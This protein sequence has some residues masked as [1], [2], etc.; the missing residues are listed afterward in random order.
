MENV[1]DTL[2]S[3]LHE[4]EIKVL[5]LKSEG[6]DLMVLMMKYVQFSLAL[7]LSPTVG[8]REKLQAR[9][10]AMKTLDHAMSGQA[11]T[12]TCEVFVEALGLKYLFSAF[13]GKGPKKSKGNS[14][15]TSE[16]TTHA[17]GIVSSLLSNLPSDSSGRIRLLTKFVENAYEKTDKLLDI[18]SSA[19]GRLNTVEKEIQTEKKVMEMDGEQIEDEDV[20]YLRR[21]D[22]G[23]YTLQTVDYILAW[24]VMEDDGV[25]ARVEIIL[26]FLFTLIYRFV[27]TQIRCSPVGVN[28]SRTLSPHFEYSETTWTKTNPHYPLD[29]SHSERLSNVSSSSSK[30]VSWSIK[31]WCVDYILSEC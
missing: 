14:A 22:G 28:R 24:L 17:L 6:V 16:V 25:R 19:Q 21:L 15:P 23:L 1:F 5:F 31:D 12:E 30:V 26:T 10:R 20:W 18:R 4:P 7:D 13:M 11:G 29:R 3:A 27:R 2:C 9:S 8:F